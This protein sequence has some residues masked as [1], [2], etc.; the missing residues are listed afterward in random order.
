MWH[1]KTK[2]P[3]ELNIKV[4]AS[5]WAKQDENIFSSYCIHKSE[6]L[7]TKDSFITENATNGFFRMWRLDLFALL[8]LKMYNT[9]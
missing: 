7:G 6:V 9:K 8:R 1:R 3:G 2:R 4:I 5:H